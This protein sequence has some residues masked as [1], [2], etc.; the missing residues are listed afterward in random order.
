M[1]TPDYDS[2]ADTITANFRTMNGVAANIEEM[3]MAISALAT[4]V[5]IGAIIL[6]ALLARRMILSGK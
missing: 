1:P 5:S 6:V 2:L 3:K 4:I